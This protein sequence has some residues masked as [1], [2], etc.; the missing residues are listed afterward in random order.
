MADAVQTVLSRRHLD[1][2]AFRSSPGVFTLVRSRDRAVDAGKRRLFQAC[3]VFGGVVAT[4]DLVGAY[5]PSMM[6]QLREA[7]LHRGSRLFEKRVRE[8]NLDTDGSVSVVY[9]LQGDRRGITIE[10]A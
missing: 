7:V 2:R 5:S 4:S 8:V 3:T 10:R 1:G 9:D 6:E